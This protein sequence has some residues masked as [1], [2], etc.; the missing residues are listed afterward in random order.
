MWVKPKKSKVSGL[1]SP[2]FRAI[3]QFLPNSTKRVL[4]G[5]Q[6]QGEFRQPVAQFGQ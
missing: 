6:I 3:A 5:M 4:S 2:R 1:P